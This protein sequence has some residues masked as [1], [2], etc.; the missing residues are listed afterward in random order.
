MCCA[1]VVYL[2]LASRFFHSVFFPLS[3]NVGNEGILNA[4]RC[5]FSPCFVLRFFR[6]SL[7]RSR[8]LFL[9]CF[10]FCFGFVAL[11]VLLMLMLHT[12]TIQEGTMTET[13]PFEQSDTTYRKTRARSRKKEE[14]KTAASEKKMN[15]YILVCKLNI[16]MYYRQKLNNDILVLPGIGRLQQQKPVR[17]PLIIHTHTHTYTIQ[18]QAYL[19]WHLAIC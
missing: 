10:F 3:E 12:R 17:L 13:E 5:L 4:E 8:R 11:F 19:P 1:F 16:V 6:S 7:A 18:Q 9:D 14:T 15:K 2:L